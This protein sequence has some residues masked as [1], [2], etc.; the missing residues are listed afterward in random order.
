MNRILAIVLTLAAF[1]AGAQD[2]VLRVVPHSNLNILDPIWTTQYMARNHGYM[3]Y[4][5]LFA[6]DAKSQIQPQMVDKWTVSPDKRLWTFTLRPGLAFHDG[7][8]VTSDD[9]IASLARW[10]KRDPMGIQ[11][12][13]F[14]ERM[15]APTPTTFRIF[16]RETCGFVLEALG[17]PSSNVPFIMPKRVAETDAFKQIEDYT[18]SGPYIFVKE[19]FKPGDR[20]VYVKNT[21]YVPRKEP[22]SGTAGGKVVY[23]DRVEWN[24]A[25][26]DAQQQVSALIK[27]EV[28]ILEQPAFESVPALQADKNVQVL[29]P[30]IGRQY[31]GRFNHLHKPF[32]NP[33]VR[34]AAIAAFAQEPF[35]RAQVGIKELYKTCESMFTCGTPYASNAGAD[36]QAKSSLKKAQELLKASGYDGTP[37]VILKPTDLAAIQKLPDVA[38]QLLR[39]AGFKVDLQAMDWNT[40]VTRRAKKDPPE[41]G[42]WNM[43][44]TQWVAPDI[45]NPISNAALDARGEKSGWFGWPDD[46]KLEALRA[47][48]ARETDAAKKKK[49]AEAIQAEAFANGTHAP[50]GEAVQPVAVRKGISGLQIGLADVY[51]NVKKH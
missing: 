34:R 39:Q 31:M 30:A 23:V 11:L 36:I 20:A 32:D 51:W 17:K 26:R 10:G 7:A 22:A 16:L 15:D 9:V 28:D 12:L 48:F 41:K 40:V 5:T 8:P 49:L 35:L 14:V 3:I 27:G 47:Q 13:T 42:G 18:G 25:L 50:L 1:A 6:T 24:L 19:E 4:D 21:K 46:P 45:W 2:K 38:A 29:L 33:A 37:V 43:F 44:F